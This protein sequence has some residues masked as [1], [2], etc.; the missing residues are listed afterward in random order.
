MAFRDRFVPYPMQGLDILKAISPFDSLS[1]ASSFLWS[2]IESLFRDWRDDS[3]EDFIVNRFGRRMYNVFFGPF[4]EKTW[5]VPGSQLS[6]DLGRQ[7]V[8]VFTL[9]DLFKRTVLGIKPKAM[10]CD[11]DPFLNQRTVYPD[12]GS[13]SIINAFLAVCLQDPRFHLHLDSRIDAVEKIGNEFV[14]TSGESRIQSDYCLSSIALT[15]LLKMLGLPV[16]GLRYVSTRFLMITLDQET[17]FGETPW[18]YF[19]DNRTRFNRVSE[20]RNMSPLMAPEGK[21]SLCFEFTTTGEDGVSKASET[22]LLDWAVSGMRKYG[23]LHVKSPAAWKVI[24]WENTYPLRTI[25]YKEKVDS[26]LHEIAQIGG[27]VPFGRLGRFE[28]LNMDHCVIEARRV[29]ASILSTCQERMI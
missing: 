23:L 15:D 4:T 2:R 19:S 14:I 9:W 6:A 13:G 27:I 3:F 24:D 10:D 28:Y 26:A 20:P 5:G 17:V 22:D 7:R 1:C 16:L 21:S 8:G 11:E 18:V 12:H 29:V 25:D